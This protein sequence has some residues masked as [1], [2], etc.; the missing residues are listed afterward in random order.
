M[1]QMPFAQTAPRPT[2][3]HSRYV[4]TGANAAEAK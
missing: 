4:P 2:R 3:S 1:T